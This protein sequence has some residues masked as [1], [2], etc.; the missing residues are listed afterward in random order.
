MWNYNY[1]TKLKMQI[2]QKWKGDDRIQD[3]MHNITYIVHS[4][5]SIAA[6]IKISISHLIFLPSIIQPCQQNTLGFQLITIIAWSHDETEMRIQIANW[7]LIFMFLFHKSVNN[8]IQHPLHDCFSVAVYLPCQNSNTNEILPLHSYFQTR[9]VKSNCVG[10]DGK[11]WLFNS[12]LSQSA[13]PGKL[14]MNWCEEPSK[15]KDQR[16]ERIQG[17][18]WQG[19]A[20]SVHFDTH[21]RI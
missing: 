21:F 14:Y 19:A 9:L 8:L 10:R 6:N 12:C 20:S 3:W 1:V 4:V 15:Q 13:K 18:Q 11:K 16:E 17:R 7:H 5:Y 2:R